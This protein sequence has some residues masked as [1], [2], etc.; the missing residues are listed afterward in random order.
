MTAYEAG[1]LGQSRLGFTMTKGDLG[2][3]KK[4][5]KVGRSKGPEGAV[6]HLKI[7]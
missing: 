2:W 7:Y 4:Q 6:I 5:S 3:E 1:T